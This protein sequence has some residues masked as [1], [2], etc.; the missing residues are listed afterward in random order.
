MLRF[1]ALQFL[2]PFCLA[3]YRSNDA[4]ILNRRIFIYTHTHVYVRE[5]AR[6]RRESRERIFFDRGR[7]NSV[8]YYQNTWFV[9]SYCG[10]DTSISLSPYCLHQAMLFL[11]M[12]SLRLCRRDPLRISSVFKSSH[13]CGVAVHYATS[14]CCCFTFSRP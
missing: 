12:P 1:S 8:L 6:E 7:I 2:K 10:S 3:W 4:E 11:F 5:R 14:L 13:C 9:S